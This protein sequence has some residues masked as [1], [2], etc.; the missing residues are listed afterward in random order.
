MPKRLELLVELV[1][2]AMIAVLTN[3]SYSEHEPQRKRVEDAARVLGVGVRFVLAGTDA[4]LDPA[5][6]SLADLS[7]GALLISADPFF[8]SRREQLVALAARYAI[9]TMHEWRESVA[10]GGLISYGAS[11]NG[12]YRL[13]GTYAG[14]IL[15]G[16][17]PR[18]LPIQQP[19]KFELVVNLKAAKALGLNVPFAI[20]AR[21]DEII[22]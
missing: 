16:A 13:L 4:D 21:A 1:P 2:G 14:K 20:L 12:M 9:P 18:D 17:K 22:E 11:L 5:F 6:A 7:A 8:N 15:N 10:A 3:P 19:T